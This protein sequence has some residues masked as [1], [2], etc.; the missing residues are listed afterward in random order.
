MLLPTITVLSVF[1][2]LLSWIV[3]FWYFLTD[4]SILPELFAQYPEWELMAVLCIILFFVFMPGISYCLFYR[5]DTKENLITCI[6]AGLFQ[7]VYNLLQM[8]A[9]FLAVWRQLTGRKGWVKTTH[10]KEKKKEE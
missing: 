10:F 6:L 2:Q 8:P 1:T 3:I 5:A 7:P 9:V 4:S